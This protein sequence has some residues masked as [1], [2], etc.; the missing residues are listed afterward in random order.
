MYKLHLSTNIKI[1]SVFHVLLLKKYS[2]DKD[3]ADSVI[4]EF[5]SD[6]EY[7][8]EKIVDFKM[9][10][11]QLHYFVKWK[12]WSNKYNKWI[13]KEDLVN[14]RKLLRQYKKRQK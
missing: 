11:N 2:E 13:K 7:E 6:E 14:V 8:I 3:I 4:Y 12:D 1:H 9:K 5:F 10:F